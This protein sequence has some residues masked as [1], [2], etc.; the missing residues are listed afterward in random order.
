MTQLDTLRDLAAEVHR[1]CPP[2]DVA[3]ELLA[4]IDLYREEITDH[5]PMDP[6]DLTLLQHRITVSLIPYEPQ[7]G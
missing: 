4:L 3:A 5:G 7:E 6:T 2:H 1:L